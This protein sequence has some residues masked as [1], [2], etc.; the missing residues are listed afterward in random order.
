VP[1]LIKPARAED[2]PI[3]IDD[4]NRDQDRMLS[5]SRED[6]PHGLGFSP[7]HPARQRSVCDRSDQVGFVFGYFPPVP[8]LT[9]PRDD[10]VRRDHQEHDRPDPEDHLKSK[11]HR[12]P[13]KTFEGSGVRLF[14]PEHPNC[15]TPELPNPAPERVTVERL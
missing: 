7:L 15:R 5:D 3:G 10:R 6:C 8:D 13:R 14:L 12:M 4:P 1:Q 2:F 9:H 11:R